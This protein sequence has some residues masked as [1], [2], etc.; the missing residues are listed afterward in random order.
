MCNYQ[1]SRLKP[2]VVRMQYLQKEGIMPLTGIS[3]IHIAVY[4]IQLGCDFIM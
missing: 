4:Q 3:R 2:L 1:V